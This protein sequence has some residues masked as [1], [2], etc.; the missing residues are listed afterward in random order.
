PYKEPVLE[1]LTNRTS[2][3]LLDYFHL[4]YLNLE[5]NKT[6]IQRNNKFNTYK[7]EALDKTVDIRSLP[8]GYHTSFPPTPSSC[9]K[10]EQD[11]GSLN[12]NILIC[13]HGYHR[14][15]YHSLENRCKHCEE[16]YTK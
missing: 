3:F 5:K 15:C 9:D 4:I 8:T 13:G 12:V 2:I 6:R 16:Y 7:L 11:L 1:E 14:E 10:C